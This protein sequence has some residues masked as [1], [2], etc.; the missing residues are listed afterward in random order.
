MQYLELYVLT[1]KMLEDTRVVPGLRALCDH[2]YSKSC[3]DLDKA[4]ECIRSSS[5]AS[6][7][8]S[9]PRTTMAWVGG[10][11]G[12][13]DWGWAASSVRDRVSNSLYPAHEEWRCHRLPR[14]IVVQHG[15]AFAPP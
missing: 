14:L 5:E 10:S 12:L 11:M 15:R 4:H 13:L 6:N 8:T 3:M 9:L 7:N 2:L 1:A